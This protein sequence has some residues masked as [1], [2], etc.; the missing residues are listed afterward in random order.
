MKIW[1]GIFLLIGIF[2]TAKDKDSDGG[3]HDHDYWDEVL[4]R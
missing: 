3:E 4:P 2:W 1:I